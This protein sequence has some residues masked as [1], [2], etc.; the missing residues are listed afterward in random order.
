MLQYLMNM[1]AGTGYMHEGVF[2]DDPTKYTRS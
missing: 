1:D 2:C